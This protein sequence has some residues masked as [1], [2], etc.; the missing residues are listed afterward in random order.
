M[1]VILP[2]MNLI[3][4][5]RFMESRDNSQQ[6]EHHNTMVWKKEKN[7]TVQEMERTML[8]DSKLSYIL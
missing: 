1:E 3:N 2:Q 6:P 7:R 5:V 4:F 8:N